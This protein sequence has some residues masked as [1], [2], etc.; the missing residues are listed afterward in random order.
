MSSSSSTIITRMGL[1]AVGFL[2]I[3]GVF[4]LSI[5]SMSY[6]I[7]FTRRPDPFVTPSRNLPL[8][9]CAQPGVEQRRRTAYY[10][11][12]EAALREYEI[13]VQ[14]HVN[15]GDEE[16]YSTTHIG[17]FS[18]GLQHDALG[19][20][21]PASYASF[22]NAVRT[23]V[24]A[25]FEAIIM[26]GGGAKLTSPQGGLAFSLEGFDPSA[27]FQPPAPA[28][29]SAWLAGEL[30]ENYWMALAR[31]INFDQYGLEPITQAAITEIGTLSDWR[32]LPPSPSTLFRGS[33][34][35]VNVGPYLSQF[36]YETANFGANAIDPKIQSYTANADYMT[37]WAE[38]LNVQN[39]F[40]PGFPQTMDPGPKRFMINGRDLSRWV[41]IDV[42]FQAYF[43]ATL[44][45]MGMGAPLKPT[46]PYVTSSDNQKGFSTFGAPHIAHSVIDVSEAA[47]RAVWFQKWIVHRKLRPEEAAARVDR[48]KNGLAVYPLHSDVIGSQAVAN[49]FAKFGSYLLPQAFAE[50][51]PTHPSYGAGHATVAGACTTMIKFWFDESF[52][53]PNPVAPSADGS[54]VNPI[55]DALTVGG[56]LNKIASNVAY[57]RNIAGVH[58]RSDAE[59]S[60][61]LGEQ[62]AVAFLREQKALYNEVLPPW[63][64][65]GFDG[66]LLVV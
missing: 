56:E 64:A 22:L 39:G 62:M 21:T 16:L 34:P 2:L 31:D 47:L 48:H 42:L 10:K 63:T 45:L 32:G 13:P 11:R 5:V 50:G 25:D 12:E 8:P 20:V 59:A 61:K 29:A 55:G 36:F 17:S 49:V 37:T 6:V 27:G 30:V 26:G 9:S 46:I 28:I 54:T 38:Y 53:L 51:A 23:G 33:A 7:S 15:N 3:I 14:C 19:Q 41:H 24:P 60:M 43:C 1:L 44:S 58:W 65:T 35:G 40:P 66:T 4:L 18:K 57:G 52:V